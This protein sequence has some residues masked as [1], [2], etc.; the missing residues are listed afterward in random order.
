MKV[1]KVELKKILLLEK[2]IKLKKKSKYIINLVCI[3]LC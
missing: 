2:T 3:L 1:N